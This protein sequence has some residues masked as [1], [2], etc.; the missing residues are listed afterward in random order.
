[1]LILFGSE[2]K[3]PTPQRFVSITPYSPCFSSSLRW[4]RGTGCQ[5]MENGFPEQYLSLYTSPEAVAG[6]VVLGVPWH[7]D[8]MIFVNWGLTPAVTSLR[9]PNF[10]NISFS[11]ILLSQSLHLYCK[12][13]NL[14]LL[15]PNFIGQLCKLVPFVWS[16]EERKS[17]IVYSKSAFFPNLHHTFK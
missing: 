5:P 8:W 4:A 16:T 13:C 6:T 1:M 12:L 14:S 9:K 3:S 17:L 7:Y 11:K 2:K 10:S 15:C